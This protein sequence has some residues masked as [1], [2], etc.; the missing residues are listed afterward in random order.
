MSTGNGRVGLTYVLQDM[1]SRRVDLTA[2]T[3]Q[4]RK[5]NMP[6]FADCPAGGEEF[7]MAIAGNA[8]DQ[9]RA[10]DV[11]LQLEIIRV[12]KEIEREG[13]KVHERATY[14]QPEIQVGKWRARGVAAMWPLVVIA[15]VAIL[16]AAI[17]AK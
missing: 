10:L 5:V 13:G 7:H 3:T 9:S 12:K 15:C 8:C 16:A 17:Y 1:E 2:S 4:L 14:P 11:L 6:K